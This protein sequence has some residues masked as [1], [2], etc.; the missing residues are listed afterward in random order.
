MFFNN[1]TC[2]LLSV[3]EQ[4][5]IPTVSWTCV[6]FPTPAFQKNLQI[7]TVDSG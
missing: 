4:Q 7:Q 3:R 5:G 2:G 6:G 1:T